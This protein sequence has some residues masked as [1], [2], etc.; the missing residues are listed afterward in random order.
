M[1]F[2]S[3]Q[4]LAEMNDPKGVSG[5]LKHTNDPRAAKAVAQQFGALLMQGMMQQ[6]DGSAMAMT[7]GTGGGIVNNMFATTI[8]KTVMSAK[9]WA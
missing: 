4:L 6:A 9:R 1:D 2:G 8:G 3:A 7:Q 5:L